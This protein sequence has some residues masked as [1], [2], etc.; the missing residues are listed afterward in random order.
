MESHIFETYKNT[1][2]P[3]GFHLHNTVEDMAMEKWVPVL[4]HIMICLTV[5]VC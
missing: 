3:N 4:L 2:R 5:N 1:V